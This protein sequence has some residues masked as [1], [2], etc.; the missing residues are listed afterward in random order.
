[1]NTF[2]QLNVLV[3]NAG[4]ALLGNAEDTSLEDWDKV[5]S[6]NSTA[7]F[8]GVRS[9]IKA[10]KNNAGS[11]I[12]I[13]SIEGIVGEPVAAAYNASKGAVR[14]FSK[15]AAL[16][17]AQQGYDIRVNSLHPGAI[18]TPMLQGLGGGNTEAGNA[19][20]QALIAKT[21]MGRLADPREMATGIL[22]LASDDSSFM[23]GA[24][25]VMDGGLTAQ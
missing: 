24:E 15:S 1:M 6:V 14:I 3:N 17:C 7:V 20:R 22:F 25:L 11:I 12:N 16:H 2:G 18:E 13:S 10:M 5:Q 19:M 9:A 4:I 8:L 21:P 23:T